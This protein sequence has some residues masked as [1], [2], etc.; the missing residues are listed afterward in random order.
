MAQII[1]RKVKDQNFIEYLNTILKNIERIRKIVRE[2]VD[3][4]RPSSYE[5]ADSNINEI[6]SNAVGIVKYDRRMK[7]INIELELDNNIPTIF[8]VGD[9]LLQVFINILINAVDALTED[10]N[11]IIIRSRKH[12]SNIII[13]IEDEGVGIKPENIS[14]IFEPFYTTKKVGKGTGLGLSVTYGIVKNLNGNIDVQSEP[15]KG[16][17]FIITL[18]RTIGSQ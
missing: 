12:K 7:S 13:E 2:L 4:A 10:S 18:P 14:K 5:A 3:F 17:I 16:T 9:Q 1:K 8:L 15:G 11:R 6:I